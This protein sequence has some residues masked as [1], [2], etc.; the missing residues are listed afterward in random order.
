MSTTQ[1]ISQYGFNIY[2][3]DPQFS[4]VIDFTVSQTASFGDADAFA[5]LD[6]LKAALPSAWGAVGSVQKFASSGT[7]YTTNYTSAPPSFT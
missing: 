1:E 4:P 5:L 7:S 2:W 3:G 6:A